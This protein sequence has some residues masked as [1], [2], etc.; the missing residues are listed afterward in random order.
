M[1]WVTV[2]RY[3]A[4]YYAGTHEKMAKTRIY[5]GKQHEPGMSYCIKSKENPKHY[6]D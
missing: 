2:Q 3:V 1:P 4:G 5:A 6:V